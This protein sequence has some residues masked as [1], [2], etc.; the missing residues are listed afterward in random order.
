MSEPIIPVCCYLTCPEKAD[1]TI[2]WGPS[3][4]DYT[5]SCTAHIGE[6]LGDAD[7]QEIERIR[8]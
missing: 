5:E 7:R 4:D 3:P 1:W 8:R 2:T 6:L